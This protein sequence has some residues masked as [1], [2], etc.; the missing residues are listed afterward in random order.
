[1]TRRRQALLLAA[2]AA[3]F[4][5]L[6]GRWGRGL[7]TTAEFVHFSVNFPT[8]PGFATLPRAELSSP[9]QRLRDD[10]WQGYPAGGLLA[11]GREGNLLVDLGQRSFIKQLLQPNKLL[12]STH[13]ARNLGP[14]PLRIG[15]RFDA[16]GMVREW[17]TFERHWDPIR[18]EATRRLAP[19]ETYNMDWILE[20]PDAQLQRPVVCDSTLEI[21]D[22]DSGAVLT[23][24]GI[25]II[26][27]A[28]GQ[29]TVTEEQP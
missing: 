24:F 22:A 3:A 23:R 8:E 9:W 19:G 10:E 5:V 17:L 14:S 28:V 26:N 2:A 20:I 21:L 1:M 7:F 27:S 4:T 11:W 29:P 13:W 12:L 6:A 15:F 25:R 18:R 16:C